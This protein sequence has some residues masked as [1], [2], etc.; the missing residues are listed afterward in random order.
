MICEFETLKPR[1]AFA[2][3]K[4]DEDDPRVLLITVLAPLIA[5]F[6]VITGVSALIIMMSGCAQ[7]PEYMNELDRQ[8][9]EDV[10]I[11]GRKVWKC[12][13]TDRDRVGFWATDDE[14]RRVS[15]VVCCRPGH[16]CRIRLDEE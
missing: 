9:Y 7:T 10:E 15:G 8:G 13:E 1:S 4:M 5:L 11:T 14:G 2:D 16:R 6:I 3:R 12:E